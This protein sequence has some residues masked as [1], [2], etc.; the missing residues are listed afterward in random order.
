MESPDSDLWQA[1]SRVYA[2]MENVSFVKE[3]RARHVNALKGLK[4]ILDAGCGI[5][6]VTVELAK[7]LDCRVLAIDH[8]PAMLGVAKRRLLRA[9]R[10]QGVTLTR[11][12]VG[13]VP[14]AN[15]TV[16]GYLS[17]N[18]LYCVANEQAVLEEMSRVVGPGGR[19]SIASARPSMDV[20]VLLEAME[21][22][23]RDLYDP[24]L[25]ECFRKFA[26]VNR[27]LRSLLKNLHE[28]DEFVRQLERSRRWRVLEATT[29]YLEQSFF[30]VAMRV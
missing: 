24:R 14:C 25:R 8:D 13:S 5:G 20:E 27:S 12:D 16:E 10:S 17:N 29:T 22:E 3:Q 6:L 15:A 9:G 26:T 23:L 7:D 4:Q 11:G 18:V 1:Y 30:V 2:L 19:A 21:A 28:P